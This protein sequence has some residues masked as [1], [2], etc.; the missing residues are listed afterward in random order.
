MT[1]RKLPPSASVANTAEDGKMVAPA[2]S[3]NS[4]VL[5]ALLSDWAPPQGR[6]LEIASG[7]GQHMAA[8]AA[9]LPDLEW[10]P[11]EIDPDRRASIDAYVREFP[12]V[13]L[14]EELDA[15]AAGWHA[16]FAGQ[17]MIVLI[18]LIHLISWQ[19]TRTIVAEVAKAL[20]PSGRFVLYGPFMR[21]GLLTSDG[22]KRFHQALTEQDPDIGY[23]ND[24]EILAL[25]EEFGLNV[26]K[27]V[28]MPA[29]NLAF[30]S[31]RPAD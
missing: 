22:D 24:T 1:K 29:N 25:F 17:N 18:N 3:R 20:A 10:Q 4:D 14:A 28:D 27:T 12:N 21:S 8:F 11:T 13:A 26:L 19:E 5:C 30:I 16:R 23:K 31:S 2:A 15:T 6:S 7:T 9:Q